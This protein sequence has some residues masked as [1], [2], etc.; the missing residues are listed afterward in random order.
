[1]PAS[2]LVNI[3]LKAH[4]DLPDVLEVRGATFP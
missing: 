4:A 2:H 3:I 1:M